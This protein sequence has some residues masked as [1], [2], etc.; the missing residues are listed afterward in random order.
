VSTTI[1]VTPVLDGEVEGNETVVLTLTAGTYA[2]GAANTGTVTI[3][4]NTPTVTVVATDAAADE[5]GPDPG[6]FTVTRTGPT[7]LALVVNYALNGTA[8]YGADYVDYGFGGQVMIPAGEVSTTIPVTPVLDGEIEGNETV[9]LMLTAGTYAIG[10]ANTGTVTI[11]DAPI[12]TTRTWIFDGDGNWEEAAKWSG[13]V[14]PRPGEAVV[15]DR[16]AGNFT[17]TIQSLV[18]PLARVPA[19]VWH[20]AISRAPAYV[21]TA[22]A[23]LTGAVPDVMSNVVESPGSTDGGS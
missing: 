22:T 21:D 20:Q 5:A 7:T 6:T 8:T 18:G 15:I 16:L 2:I 1:P 17:I 12:L 11:T 14:V 23:E 19:D 13:S 4:E 3:G 10:A 9:V